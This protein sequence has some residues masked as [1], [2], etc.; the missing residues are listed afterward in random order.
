MKQVL[1]QEI[2]IQCTQNVLIFQS[3][4]HEKKI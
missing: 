1:P 3:V 4:K 2:Q